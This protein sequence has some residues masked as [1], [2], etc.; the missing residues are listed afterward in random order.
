MPLHGASHPLRAHNIQLDILHQ[1]VPQQHSRNHIIELL[2][3]ERKDLKNF[4]MNIFEYLQ[5]LF[6]HVVAYLVSDNLL[7]LVKFIKIIDLFTN[8]ILIIY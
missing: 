4:L 3:L 2:L 8:R 7:I 6:I 5:G 1:I